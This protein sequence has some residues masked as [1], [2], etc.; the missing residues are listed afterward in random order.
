MTEWGSGRASEAA[1]DGQ[2]EEEEERE[3]AGG[4]DE[5]PD[6]AEAAGEADET[7]TSD[8]AVA[9][10]DE[11]PR[12]SRLPIATWL[13]VVILI[14]VVLVTYSALRIAGEQR[15][16]SCVQ[17]VSAQRHRQPQPASA[18]AER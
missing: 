11:E 12:P 7:E 4:G 13:L 5:S 2:E 3:P 1:S 9:E 15:Y 8:A 16:Q 6:E 10:K 18:H 17:A 14:A